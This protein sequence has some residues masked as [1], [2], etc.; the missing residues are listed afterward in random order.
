[1]KSEIR[2]SLEKKFNVLELRIYNG[3]KETGKL[4]EK[5]IELEKEIV[6]RDD[7]QTERLNEVLPRK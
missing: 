6:K 2:S 4:K 3:E 7:R 5:V 1:M